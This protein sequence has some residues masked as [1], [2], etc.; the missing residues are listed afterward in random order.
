MASRVLQVQRKLIFTAALVLVVVLAAIFFGGV[1]TVFPASLM[2]PVL[3]IALATVL[4][5]LWA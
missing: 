3:M 5:F 2:I 4:F 1:L